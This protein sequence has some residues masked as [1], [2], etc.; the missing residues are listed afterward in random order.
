MAIPRSQ[1]NDV[2]RLV[3]MRFLQHALLQS[4]CIPLAAPSQFNDDADGEDF[5]RLLIADA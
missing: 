1:R 5:E 3:R 2:R 4:L